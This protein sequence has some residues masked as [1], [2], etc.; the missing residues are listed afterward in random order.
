MI[1]ELF[2]NYTWHIAV[3]IPKTAM[4]VT[5]ILPTAMVVTAMTAIYSPIFGTFWVIFGPFL[6]IF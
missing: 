6:K 3:G 2:V 1:L 5:A 4:G